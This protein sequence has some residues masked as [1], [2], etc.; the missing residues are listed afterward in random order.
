MN[1]LDE[2]ISIQLIQKVGL[3]EENEDFGYKR[4]VGGDI[5]K[6]KDG[7][8]IIETRMGNWNCWRKYC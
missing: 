5:Y 1:K 7:E 4:K 8:R 6:E 2:A 3:L